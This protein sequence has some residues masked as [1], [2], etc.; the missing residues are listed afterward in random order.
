[1]RP[2]VRSAVIAESG[3][4]VALENPAAVAG[5]CLDFLASF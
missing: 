2:D 1:L 3:H 5:A 4:N